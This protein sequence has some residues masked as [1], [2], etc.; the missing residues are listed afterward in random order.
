MMIVKMLGGLALFLYGMGIMGDGLKSSSAGALKK[1][2]EKVTSNPVKS[3]FLGLIITAV[4]QSSTATIVIV[5]GLIGAG[6][7][8]LEQSV[9][10]VMGANVGTTITAQ[11]L[12]LMDVQGSGSGASVFDLFTPDSLAPLAAIIGIILIMFTTLRPDRY[13]LRY[14]LYRS[15]QHDRCHDSA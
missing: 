13:R 10:I 5:V 6:V 1:A 3:F 15:Y 8:S 9:G 11:I 2:L 14:S 12:R 4:I 7:L